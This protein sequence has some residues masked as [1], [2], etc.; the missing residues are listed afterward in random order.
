[1]HNSISTANVTTLTYIGMKNSTPA[2]YAACMDCT[3]AEEVPKKGKQFLIS[4]NTTTSTAGLN[5]TVLKSSTI[6]VL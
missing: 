2:V 6:V 4:Y 1:M 5:V 3:S